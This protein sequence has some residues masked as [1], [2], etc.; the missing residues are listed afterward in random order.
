MEQ[1]AGV[2]DD[3][4]LLQALLQRFMIW[5]LATFAMLADLQTAVGRLSALHR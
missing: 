4:I 3:Q 5:F 2:L 1:S